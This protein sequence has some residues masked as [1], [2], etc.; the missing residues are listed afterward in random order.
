MLEFTAHLRIS[1]TNNGVFRQQLNLTHKFGA[2]FNLGTE[3]CV[4]SA[5]A[6][7]CGEGKTTANAIRKREAQ[8][9]F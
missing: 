2:K 8:P 5:A 1:A 6:G 7:L 9:R 3:S 4:C